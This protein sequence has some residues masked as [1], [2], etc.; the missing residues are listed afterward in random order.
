[1]AV[2][3]MGYPCLDLMVVEEEAVFLP[4]ISRCQ[5]VSIDPSSEHESAV[6]GLII[7]E[8]G[9]CAGVSW[10]A[11]ADL[12]NATPP[13][14]RNNTALLAHLKMRAVLLVASLGVLSAVALPPPQ[15]SM[16]VAALPSATA[17]VILS[18]GQVEA[19]G[20]IHGDF[21][22]T[23][24]QLVD[25]VTGHLLQRDD[26]DNSQTSTTT[27]TSSTSTSTTTTSTSTSTSST[28]TSTST[29]ST[30]SSSSTSQSTSTTTSTTS[31]T[32][33]STG[34][35]STTSTKTTTASSTSSTSTATPTETSESDKGV[36]KSSMIVGSAVVGAFAALA[37][38]FVLFLLYQKT[39]EWLRRRRLEKLKDDDAGSSYSVVPLAEEGLGKNRHLSVDASSDR[40]SLMFNRNRSPSLTF[41]VER[42]GN[43]DSVTQVYYNHDDAS[44]LAYDQTDQQSRRSSERSLTGVMP[45]PESPYDPYI[46]PTHQRSESTP[47]VVVSMPHPEDYRSSSDGGSVSP[48]SLEF[49][50][51]ASAH[52]E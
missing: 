38:G 5:N 40:E 4:L 29:S 3:A 33:T 26:S 35:S 18:S 11:T 51:G 12:L 20:I 8:R 9:S 23:F 39:R 7:Y 48:Q 22:K 34:S 41:I 15:P 28:S 50:H 25:E 21:V 43:R 45:S 37:L 32:S 24:R 49:R 44:I 16:T 36:S 6:A 1:M 27:S 2:D 14:G 46:S 42:S 17:P 19:R 31:S 10:S 13:S 47:Q 52:P 30:S